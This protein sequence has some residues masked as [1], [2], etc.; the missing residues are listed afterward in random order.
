MSASATTAHA[1]EQG[2]ARLHAT[3]RF[4]T[5]VTA[6]FVACEFLQW[7]PTFMAP[8]LAAALLAN[9]P[10]RPPMKMTLVLILTMSVAALFSFAIAS[11]LRGTP[12]V[13]F[14]VIVLCMFLSF[15]GM[16]SGRPR[17]PALLLLICLATIPVVV[18]TAPAQAGILPKALI[19]GIALALVLIWVVHLL[20]PR[21]AAPTPASA[22]TPSN[23]T[24]LTLALLST[25]VVAPLMLIYL[26]FGLADALPVIIT[27]VMLVVNF[28]PQR[29]RTHAL[30]MILG[31]LAGGLFG[32]LMHTLLLTMPTL[33]FL[34]L[35][36]FMVLLGF[37]QRI[38]AGGPAA[39]VAVITCNAM[40]IVFGSAIASGPGSLSVWLTRLF[41]FALAGA[42]GVGMMYLLWHRATSERSA[43]PN[44]QPTDRDRPPPIP[45]PETPP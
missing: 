28:D 42:F 27:T 34:T 24:P 15:H 35:L 44:P 1:G 37:G 29:S 7:T 43:P 12:T 40:L 25:A 8:V 18:M 32:L 9:L 13:L 21:V 30:A 19:R 36:L 22:I 2:E 20:W 4:A 10:T 33:P 31:N 5:G 39:V 16:L 17:L 26:L 23:A 38:A 41:Q 11:L 45:K 3:L 6:A 14:G